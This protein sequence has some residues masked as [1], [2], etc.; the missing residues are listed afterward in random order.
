MKTGI[1]ATFAVLGGLAAYAAEP[2]EVVF[3]MPVQRWL[4]GGFGFHNSEATMLP[5]M[6][7]EFRDERVYKTFREI[8]PTYARVFAGYADWTK[9]AM[10]A[11]ADFYD[12]TFRRAGTTIY[13]VPGRFPYIHKDFDAKDHFE[14]IAT[15]LAYLVNVRKLTKLR[16]YAIANELS[17][18]NVCC[19][20]DR[21]GKMDLYRDYCEEAYCAF[22]R[23]GLDIGLQTTDRSCNDAGIMME[24]FKWAVK[25]VDAVTDTYCWHHYD[26]AHQP[27]EPG[28]YEW[29]YTN[30]VALVKL[31]GR[32]EKRVSLGEYGMQGR[33]PQETRGYGSGVMRDDGTFSFRYPDKQHLAAISQVE[34]ALAAINAGTVSAVKWTLFD[35]PHPFLRE[36]GDSPAEKGRYDVSRFSGHGLQIRYNKCGLVA[37]NDEEHDYSARADLYTL[38]Y[39]AKFFRKG[40]RILPSSCVGAGLVASGITQPDG[41][42]TYALVNWGE[43]R[44]VRVK[45]THPVSQP[46]RLYVYDSANPPYNAFN[47]LQPASGTVVAEVGV[48]TVPMP[49][50]SLVFATTD[51]TDRTPEAVKGVRLDGDRLIWQEADDPEHAYYRV[52]RDG[53]QVAST[54]ATFFE[55]Q[56]DAAAEYDVRSVDKWGNV[57]KPGNRRDDR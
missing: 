48:F 34:M 55:R 2:A 26:Y 1:V 46:L 44:N 28:L 12:A 49:A 57:G 18:G 35:Y 21:A 5:M 20:F 6:S 52:Y 13:M 50:K 11:F 15:N 24:H 25:N 40:G 54:V 3:D 39:L 16:Y 10:D 38:G 4:W 27:G 42:A 7:Q 9:E 22:K 51:Y 19:W 32:Y 23:H 31:A 47:D 30:S 45:T 29:M 53:K 56:I 17:V 41:S 37:W 14:R 36:D 43:E 8:S 33:S